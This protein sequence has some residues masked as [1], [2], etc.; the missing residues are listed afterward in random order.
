MAAQIVVE[1]PTIYGL[2]AGYWMAYGA[3]MA[4]ADG[5]DEEAEVAACQRLLEA[6]IAVCSFVPT[7]RTEAR[8]KSTFVSELAAENNGYLEPQCIKALVRSMSDAYARRAAA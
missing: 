3:L 2:I 4:V 8:V 1:E 5:E 6:E 7:N